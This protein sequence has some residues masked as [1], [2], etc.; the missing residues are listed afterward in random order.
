MVVH[1][2]H[3]ATDF[4]RKAA[5]AC[6][7]HATERTLQVPKIF[8]RE[9]ALASE[10]GSHKPVAALPLRLAS[11]VLAEK[12]NEQMAEVASF[13]FSQSYPS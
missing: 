5:P 8:A 1:R 2:R 11:W 13:R 9:D 3:T 12:T 6:L 7:Q 4:L 10:G